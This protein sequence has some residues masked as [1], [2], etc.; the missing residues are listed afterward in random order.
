MSTGDEV[1]PPETPT[2]GPGKIRDA[3]RFLL[4][5]L[6][7]ELGA[8]IEFGPSLEYRF[9]R[10]ANSAWWLDLPLRLAYTLDSDFDS[11]G[12]VFQPRLAWRKP[13]TRLGETKLRVNFG[14]LYA[15]DD[16]HAYYYS[17]ADDEIAPQRPA[18]DA[19]GGFSGFRAEF[20]YSRRIGR[21]W[22]GGFLR[23]DSLRD[24]EVEDSPLVRDAESWMG[25]I[26]L[27]WVFHED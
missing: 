18:Y 25:G 20:T 19:D 22:L 9:Y 5:G 7:D 21:Y 11:A 13:A 24:S 23:Y 2:L 8:T 3:N 1:V 14:P 16:Y 17:V 27:A 12:Y 4:R 10:H 26:A 15:S 6:L